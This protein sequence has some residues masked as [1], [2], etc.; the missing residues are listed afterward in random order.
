MPELIKG[1]N[2]SPGVGRGYSILWTPTVVAIP[3]HLEHRAVERELERFE[4][5]LEQ[6]KEQ[7]K[8]LRERIADQVGAEHVLLVDVQL[9]I[10]EDEQFIR[11]V[12]EEIKKNKINAEWALEVL[13][14]E[15]LKRFEA[16]ED[17][18][19]RER[20]ADLFDVIHRL[21]A[22][23]TRSSSFQP[24]DIHGPI[25]IVS[26]RLAPS[27]LLEIQSEL[28]VKGLVL[29]PVSRTAHVAILARALQLPAV[30]S[31]QN[32]Y[33]RFQSGKEVLVDGY[34][35]TIVVEP[36]PLQIREYE[37]KRKYFAYHIRKFPRE[38]IPVYT[39][40][41]F[42]VQCFAN[43]EFAEEAKR[44]R[45]LG[46]LG[47][48][49]FRSEYLY[50]QGNGIPDEETHFQAYRKILSSF[51][52]EP[53]IIR[54]ADLGF[55]KFL[56][57]EAPIHER[58]PALGVRGP[59][60]FLRKRNLLYPQMRALLRLGL[61]G[62]IQILIPFVSVIEEIIEILEVIQEV[63]EDFRRKGIPLLENPKIGVMIEIPS[64]ARMIPQ[65]AEYVDF[66]SIG[67]NDL[68]QYFFAVERDHDELRYI[69][70]PY[71]PAFLKLL[72]QIVQDAYD[73][74]L[75]LHVCGEIASDPPSVIFLVGMGCN[76]LSMVPQWIPAIRYFVQTLS[77][78]EC[79]EILEQVLEL[80]TGKEV[81]E[82]ILEWIQEHYPEGIFH[83]VFRTTKRGTA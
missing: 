31:I 28:D 81:E 4:R 38:A 53:V 61:E 41:G 9:H 79:Q 80:H 1:M 11:D 73:A 55:D 8:K 14:R 15:Y 2:L 35:G 78:E 36:S 32:I 6:T 77:R 60:L 63:Q 62:N 37:S 57:G 58:N 69:Y 40:D 67:T 24:H 74:H 68:I 17:E 39:Q 27:H 7:L 47:V 82:H 23:L 34:E 30:G 46:A 45:K 66:I 33:E 26:E 42:Q 71:H 76:T 48:G 59:R 43:L 21:Q 75:E 18:Y 29:G 83:H 13:G 44:A 51:P 22:N 54:L 12:I 70:H 49:L 25:V 52:N 10:L 3:L 16:I 20:S 19:I 72:T 56:P 64:M 5:A 50:M 65:L